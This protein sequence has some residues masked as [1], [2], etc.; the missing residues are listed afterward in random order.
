M[1]S[2]LLFIIYFLFLHQKVLNKL[3][4]TQRDDTLMMIGFLMNTV[5]S[6]GS[7]FVGGLFHGRLDLF[8]LIFAALV[9]VM[10]YFNYKRL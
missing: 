9:Y 2:L 6:S 7:T 3:G 10:V 5:I 8:S 1:I 4:L